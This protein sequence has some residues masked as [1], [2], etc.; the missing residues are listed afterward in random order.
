MHLYSS[1][2]KE[3]NLSI[4]CFRLWPCP[5][6][7]PFP[8]RHHNSSESRRSETSASYLYS[9]TADSSLSSQAS[10]GAS[11]CWDSSFQ[12]RTSQTEAYYRCSQTYSHGK[13]SEPPAFQSSQ[14]L[15]FSQHEVPE[16]A[17]SFF[18]SDRYTLSL[19][20]PERVSEHHAAPWRK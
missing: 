10:S 7:S 14:P 16:T 12:R 3:K 19:Q 17:T 11:S 6:V 4:L 8:N 1:V 9:Q 2:K 15:S 20:T 13:C 5:Q 18:R